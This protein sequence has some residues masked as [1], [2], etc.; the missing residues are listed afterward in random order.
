MMDEL[1]SALDNEIRTNCVIGQ[2]NF[3]KRWKSQ[4]TCNHD[5]NEV[6]RTLIELF[7]DKL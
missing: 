4:K 3:S 1:F 2:G 5:E 7:F 6:N